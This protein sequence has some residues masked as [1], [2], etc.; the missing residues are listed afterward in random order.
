MHP[1]LVLPALPLLVVI[2]GFLPT[3]GGS[4]GLLNRRR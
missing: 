2:F 4:N 3:S 1:V